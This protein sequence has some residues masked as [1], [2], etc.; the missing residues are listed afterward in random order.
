MEYRP[1]RFPKVSLPSVLSNFPFPLSIPQSGRSSPS[2]REWRDFGN[3]PAAKTAVPI[4]HTHQFLHRPLPLPSTL[5]KV[6]VEI[7]PLYFTEVLFEIIHKESRH[8]TC[9]KWTARKPYRRIEE[10]TGRFA[11]AGMDVAIL[12]ILME[13]NEEPVTKERKQKQCD[14]AGAGGSY[15]LYLSIVAGFDPISSSAI[16]QTALANPRKSADCVPDSPRPPIQPRSAGI[17][18]YTFFM[19][20]PQNRPIFGPLP[21]SVRTSFMNGPLP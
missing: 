6:L 4:C 5:G 14:A 13:H 21:P 2:G 10:K 9:Q 11:P 8:P 18:L 15:R 17:R 16:S 3:R 20:C 7:W 19:V 1:R 12:S